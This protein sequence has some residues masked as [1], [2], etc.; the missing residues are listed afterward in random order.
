[1]NC[2]R[3]GCDTTFDRSEAVIGAAS[4]IS[5]KYYCSDDCLFADLSS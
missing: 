2:A 3:D 5:E 4:P 1:M